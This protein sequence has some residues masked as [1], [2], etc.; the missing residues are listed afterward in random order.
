MGGQCN[1][2]FPPSFYY[3]HTDDEIK[4]AVDEAVRPLE[5]MLEE[6]RASMRIKV[7]KDA[8][9]DT[10]RKSLLRHISAEKGLK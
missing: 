5:K 8:I 2:L 4:K 10:S 7:Y 3:T 9:F 6:K 1:S